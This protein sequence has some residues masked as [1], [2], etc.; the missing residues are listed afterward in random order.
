MSLTCFAKFTL[1]FQLFV[2]NTY[3][4]R[5]NFFNHNNWR[6]NWNHWIRNSQKC[7]LPLLG[8]WIGVGL[9]DV[10]QSWGL[11]RGWGY[12]RL[13][14]DVHNSEP[15][16]Q[17]GHFE[18]QGDGFWAPWWD[19]V[20]SVF[21]CCT[22]LKCGKFGCLNFVLYF[23]ILYN[24]LLV[25]SLLSTYIQCPTKFTSTLWSRNFQNV[26]AWLCWN[27]IIFSEPDFKW[28]QI[29]A[30]SNSPKMLFLS[31]L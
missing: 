12:P 3:W 29:L 9:I 6:W 30:N 18:P 27:L 7:G 15:G 25:K 4:I 13:G 28:N 21:K 14:V 31:I 24:F 16:F 20:Q 5:L 1:L 11:D 23:S 10:H 22:N 2:Y 17:G 19:V 8:Q 26:K